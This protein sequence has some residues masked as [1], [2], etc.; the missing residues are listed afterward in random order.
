M[1]R[2]RRS[3][4]AAC[5]ETLD[6]QVTNYVITRPAREILFTVTTREDKYKA[7]VIIDTFVQRLGDAAAAGVYKMTEAL[8][9]HA[10]SAIATCAFPLC[11]GWLWVGVALGRRQALLSRMLESSSSS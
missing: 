10:P 9:L 4:T 7:K 3:V 1:S 2:T 8:L 11:V 5:I 6:V